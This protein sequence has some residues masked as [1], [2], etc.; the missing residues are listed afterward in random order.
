MIIFLTRR[1]AAAIAHLAAARRDRNALRVGVLL[2]V[3]LALGA[4]AGACGS[5]AASSSSP[6][7]SAGAI[8]VTD[9]AGA[10]VRLPAPATRIVSL[11]PANTE[12]VY[13]IGAG[14]KLVAGTSYDDYPAKATSLPKIG[15]FSNPSVEKIASFQPDLVL[16]AAG[17]QA[18]V[19]GKLEKLGMKVY[20]VDPTTY[21]G[22]IDDITDLGR[23]TGMS[24]RAEQVAQAMRKTAEDV[25]ASV[26]SSSRPQVFLEIYSKP[27]MTAG[28][29]TFID[30][31]IKMA[32]GSNLGASAG[33]GFPDFSTEVLFKEDPD[34][35][36]ADSGSMSRPGDIARRAGFSV[37]TAVV[38][39]RVF[40]IDDD[41]IARP[42]P[43]LAQGLR[44]LAEMIHP[45]VRATP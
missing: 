32:G 31:M 44:K 18:G 28:T 37:L 4:A 43:R 9:D 10:A 14:G 15:D 40:V 8:V 26:A 2:A 42:G 11:A 41:L 12:I 36:V 24:A 39:G 1:L 3:A 27:L 25:R 34:V 45:E 35:Y 33:A 17:I 30:D 13:A 16:A 19:R 22:V 5:G 20:V 21:A 6:V 29:R 7:P 38:K 23:L